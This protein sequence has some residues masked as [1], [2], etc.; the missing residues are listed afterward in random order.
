M[1]HPDKLD[2]SPPG[3]AVGSMIA[4]EE[5]PDAD[6]Q[7][8]TQLYEV[9]TRC[10]HVG[11]YVSCLTGIL[12]AAIELM[13]ADA[14][15][16][17]VFDHDKRALHF[18]AHRGF[19]ARFL[20]EIEHFDVDDQTPIVAAL[21][22]GTRLIVDDL[23]QRA[24]W[25]SSMRQVLLDA[26]VR[27]LQATPLVDGLGELIGIISTHYRQ[28]HHPSARALRFMDLLA[29]QA[30]DYLERKRAELAIR[31][32][33]ERFR[34]F[35]QAT[36]D[37]V[38]RMSAD[39]GEIT[40]LRGREFIAERLES[41]RTWL[42]QYIHPDDQSLV[43]AAVAHAIA[44]KGIFELEHRF[45]RADGT[46]G[47]TASRAIPIFDEDGDICEWFGT[48][49]DITQRKLTE[50]AL[51]AGEARFHT[52]FDSIDEGYCIACVTFDESGKAIDY[53]FEQVN[54]AFEAQTGI[55]GAVG[56]S[57][58]E[59]S[60]AH[61]D[62]WFDVYG[63]VASTG[64]PVRFMSAA[65][66]LDRW[67]DVYAFR[68]D[69]PE[70]HRVAI[71][72]RD[73]SERRR[74]EDMVRESE[75]R[76]RR[77][78]EQLPAGVGVMDASGAWTLC[79]SAMKRFLPDGSAHSMSSHPSHWHAWDEDGR[80][81]VADDWPDRRALRG[82]TVMPGKEM[83]YA[84][85][86]GH[87][88]WVRTSA[89]PSKYEGGKVVEA[90]AV[91][92]DI[93]QMKA[94]EQAMRDTD[95][96]K[97]Q[98]L[99]TLSHE[100]RNPLAPIRSGLEILRLVG[101]SAL[102][103]G[104]VLDMITRQVHH[105]VR[106]VDD[107]M[108]VSRI[109]GGKVQLRKEHVELSSAVLNAIEIS[110]PLIKA[111]RHRLSVHLAKSPMVVEGDPVRLAQIIANL[112][113]NAAKYTDNGGQIEIRSDTDGTD[114]VVTVQDNGIGIAPDLLSCIFD[115]FIQVE[116][117]DGNERAQGGLGIGLA[118]V[119][120]LVELH[121]GAVT[122]HSEGPGRGS[123]FQIRLPLL[124]EVSPTVS[125]SDAPADI[126]PLTALRTLI[127]D[128]NRDAAESLCMLLQL[129]GLDVLT[130]HDGHAALKALETYAADV[131]ILDIGMPHMDGY[132][133]ARR[134]RGNPATAAMTL[135]AVTGWGQDED[136]LRATQAGIDHHLVKPIDIGS[137]ERILEAVALARRH[138]DGQGAGSAP[139]A[140]P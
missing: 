68:I 94:A 13:G 120:S 60:P 87:E 17:E 111:A 35:T 20:L 83:L 102:E 118:L 69:E 5:P 140:T 117:I 28:P 105:M 48:A 110:G 7:A 77:I 38:Y 70:D 108:D 127:V 61:E 56:R 39:W 43:T 99:A 66:S 29:R 53:V 16:F 138:P 80:P 54:H 104:A 90:C 95:R 100:L 18:V 11:N 132:E 21:K 91:L 130:R 12:D 79:N 75:V 51:Q 84:D 44:T 74:A 6:L 52:L 32:S 59:I 31:T 97:D 115:P 136:R 139:S 23:A 101:P 42:D 27:A 64:E 82:E 67:F 125:S 92:L 71:L 85:D 37:I 128:D 24:D 123:Q 36:S 114:A 107:L 88:T 25:P 1:D 113:N 106:L 89:A 34:A 73:I 57:M 124:D 119:K 93:T 137:L 19:D 63:K 26:D 62:Y 41:G 58:R 8:M 133:L 129:Q 49:S 3:M 134:I 15:Y 55:H 4:H 116:Q 33:E 96:R 40:H 126:E 122:A 47:W 72:F 131:V 112:L 109:A 98:F 103:A 50:R 78:I 76:L 81:I 22:R 65:A 46:L 2:P 14:G 121:G 9:G 10:A 135:V 30:T 86:A 45:I